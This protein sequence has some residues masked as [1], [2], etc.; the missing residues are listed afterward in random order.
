MVRSVKLERS[1]FFAR[2]DGKSKEHSSESFAPATIGRRWIGPALFEALRSPCRT[3]DKKS[4]GTMQQSSKP[5]ISD[6]EGGPSKLLYQ[7]VE[8]KAPWEPR[9][10]EGD[11]HV[12]ATCGFTRPRS[13][14]ED[15]A[16]HYVPDA[17]YG[18]GK[19]VGRGLGG[20]LDLG[21]GVGRGVAVGVG[22]SGGRSCGGCRRRRGRG[23]SGRSC[24]WCRCWSR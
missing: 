18:R 16:L 12:M 2:H 7:R 14:T 19:G 20:G 9:R 24:S 21:V 3:L 17:S 11:G 4:A 5:Q 15:N 6:W 10:V 13:F 1:H 8:R 23:R 22:W